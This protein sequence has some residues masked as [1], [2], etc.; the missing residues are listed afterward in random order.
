M[1]RP[2]LRTTAVDGATDSALVEKLRKV[3]A[4]TT[5]PEEGEA[6]AA[7]AM[8]QKLL[9][10]HNLEIADLEQKGAQP[11]ASVIERPH[12]LGKAAFKWKLDLAEAVA[13]HYYC[14]PI[15]NRYS[16]RV[17]FVGRP[18]NVDA[19][20]LLY[21]WLIQQIAAVSNVKRKEHAELTGNHVDPLRWQVAFG[22]GA[23]MRLAE[24]LDQIKDRR[25]RAAAQ[26]SARTPDGEIVALVLHHAA[27]VSDYMEEHHGRRVDGQPTKYERERRE[28]WQAKQAKREMLRQTDLEA[29]Y[30]EC[31]WARPETPEQKAEREKREEADRKR[32]ARNA[33]R[34]KGRAYREPTAEECRRES[35][36]GRARRDGHRAADNI[37]LEPFLSEGARVR[38]EI[39]RKK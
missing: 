11:A 28:Y 24:R 9:T 35:E 13:A 14:A 16:K 5:S 10:Q 29:Y 39:G 6:A 32:E 19:L 4:L 15:I 1:V 2:S 23:V 22:E 21:S 8:L 18:D 20:Q 27:E 38:G 7:S 34:R 17:A 36:K 26:Q 25:E 33:R 12:D 30:R 3:L 31:P 37:N